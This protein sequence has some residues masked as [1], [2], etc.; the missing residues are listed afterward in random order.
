MLSGAANRPCRAVIRLE[1][2]LCISCHLAVYLVSFG[3]VSRA[4]TE[5]IPLCM[6]C[7]PVKR[8][9]T[10]RQ[11]ARPPQ[12]GRGQASPAPPRRSPRASFPGKRLSPQGFTHVH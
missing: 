10:R 5:E 3:C 7:T 9:L 6:R 1:I 4:Q 12:P 8:T 11:A 2:P